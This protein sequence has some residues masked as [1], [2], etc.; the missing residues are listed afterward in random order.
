MLARISI[1]LSYILCIGG[2]AQ[3]SP[4][5]EVGTSVGTLK[6]GDAFFNKSG[7]SSS[8]LGFIGSFNFYVPITSLKRMIH[9][10]LGIQNR[11]TIASNANGDSFQMVTPN[12]A[13]RIEIWR[14]Y[15]GGG[16][17][18]VAIG[19]NPGAS[20][21]FGE[22]GLIWKVI[23]EFQ[24]AATAALEFGTPKA[25]GT[26]PNPIMEYGLRFRFPINPKEV[27]GGSGVDFDGFRYPFGFMK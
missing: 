27:A 11:F 24:I 23:P 15:V 21:Y 2:L 8:G 6:N 26:S 13:L 12:L 1:L 7:S 14:L 22:G 19:G 17:A 9:L 3:A 4:Y 10:D 25:G 5:F 16:Y 20:A 18:P